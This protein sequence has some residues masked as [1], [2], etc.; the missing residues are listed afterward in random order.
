[1][2]KALLFAFALFAAFPSCAQVDWRQIKN[3]PAYQID[4]TVWFP[5][6]SI[7]AT[8]IHIKRFKRVATLATVECKSETGDAVINFQRDDGSPAA[9]LTSNLTCGTSFTSGTLSATEK[10][11]VTGYNLTFQVIS[12]TAKQISFVITYN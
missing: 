10:N 1:M 3:K 7:P 11:F 4:A 9:V 2:K 5:D 6:T 8:T 12:G